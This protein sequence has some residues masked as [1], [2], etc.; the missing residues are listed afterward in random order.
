[1]SATEKHITLYENYRD[2]ITEKR[3]RFIA[4][5]ARVETRQ[6]AND[7]VA[8]ISKEFPDARH[9]VYAY[10][11]NAENYVKYSDDGEPQGTGGMPVLNVIKGQ[12]LIDVAVVVT[13]YFGGILLG[14]GG[15][16]RAYSS[17]AAL[18]LQNA[19]K[20]E[21]IPVTSYRYS[22]DY[23]TFDIISSANFA[24]AE[25]EVLSYAEQVNLNINVKS[26]FAES[27]ETG[28]T[29]LLNGAKLP[30]KTGTS[31]KLCKI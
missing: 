11:I 20:A 8:A 19:V 17:A 25:I 27:F 7:F 24:G 22:C 3:S 29:Q 12:N 26:E 16:S 18:A 31:Q 15:L 9:N 5:V 1:M 14:T 6:E 30:E 10:M 23:K 21:K 28:W 4:S 2:E 13:R